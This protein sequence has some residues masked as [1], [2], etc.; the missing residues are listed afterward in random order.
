MRLCGRDRRGRLSKTVWRVGALRATRETPGVGS[1]LSESW[2]ELPRPGPLR[3]QAQTPA[4]GEQAGLQPTW[5]GEAGGAGNKGG[6]GA[7]WRRSRSREAAPLLTR[8]SGAR[9]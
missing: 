6:A 1:F 7:G 9:L 4:G 8:A 3:A 5:R 2:T